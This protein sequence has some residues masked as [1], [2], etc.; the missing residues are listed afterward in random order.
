MEESATTVISGSQPDPTASSLV[1]PI[2]KWSKEVWLAATHPRGEIGE[3]GQ[4]LNV[5][6]PTKN[7]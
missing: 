4:F 5:L 7:M 1:A 3:H 6:N 2:L